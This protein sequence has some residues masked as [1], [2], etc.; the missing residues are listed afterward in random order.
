MADLNDS[1]QIT[2]IS[3]SV[4]PAKWILGRASELFKVVFIFD[5][6]SRL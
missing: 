6:K 1:G 3:C 4:P 2:V 5:E